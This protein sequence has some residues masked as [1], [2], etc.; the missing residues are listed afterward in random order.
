MVRNFATF[1]NLL[2]ERGMVSSWRQCV[3]VSPGPSPE[4]R[5]S[6]VQVIYPGKITNFDCFRIGHIGHMF[7]EHS[8][9]LVQATEE[10]LKQMKIDMRL[11]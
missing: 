4:G 6:P 10:V 8:Q 2:N 1:Y 11:G 5:R 9:Q 7:P 3:R